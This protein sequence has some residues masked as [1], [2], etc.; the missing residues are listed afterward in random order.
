MPNEQGGF[1]YEEEQ[2]FIA[3]QMAAANWQPPPE[4]NPTV[5]QQNQQVADNYAQALLSQNA[6]YSNQQAEHR[7]ILDVLGTTQGYGLGPPYTASAQPYNGPPPMEAQPDW[8]YDFGFPGDWHDFSSNNIST[9]GGFFDFDELYHN[10]GLPVPLPFMSGAGGPSTN[11]YRLLPPEYRHPNFIMRAGQ[12][13]NRYG[14]NMYGPYGG[15]PV[16]EELNYPAW[17]SGAGV[18]YPVAYSPS[19]V[20]WAISGWPGQLGNYNIHSSTMGQG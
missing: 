6:E 16:N 18:G 10:R 5:E 9:G 4:Q 11:N 17:R 15:P 13:I 3:R 7:G 20:S 19:P 12:I 1:T 2:E 14:P 8:N